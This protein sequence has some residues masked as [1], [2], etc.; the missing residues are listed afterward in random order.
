MT[1]YNGTWRPEGHR[2]EALEEGG[3]WVV[4]LD[5]GI[6]IDDVDDPD[7]PEFRNVAR[8]RFIDMLEDDEFDLSAEL[9]S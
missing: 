2:M 7:S 3:V 4:Y 5:T 8:Q 6:T 9:E 1:V